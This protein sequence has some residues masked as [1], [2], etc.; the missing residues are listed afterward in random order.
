M[1]IDPRLIERRKAVAE[2]RAARDVGRL[3]RML[4]LAACL[5]FGA[6]LAFSPWLSVAEVRT[7][8]IARSAARAVLAE[9]GVV[10][11]A[12]MIT[13]RPGAVEKALES[14]PWVRSAEV[15]RR[16]PDEVIV[17]VSEREPVAW[18]ETAEGWAR[19]DIDGAA[20][21]GPTA[22]DRTLPRVMLASVAD[23]ES[24]VVLGAIEFAAHL[25][26]ALSSATHIGLEE[27]ELWATV[28]QRRVRLGRPAE[29]KAKALSLAAMLAYDPA[30]DATLNLMAPTRPAVGS[31]AAMAAAEAAAEEAA[32]EAAAQAE[33][34]SETA[35]EEQ[36][37][38]GS[39]T[40]TEEQP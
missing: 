15:G 3:L 10:S 38:A 4:S 30:P 27:G 37:A 24:R 34:E 22:P 5:G 17:R 12:A 36:P 40:A 20:L 23:E 7:A 9:S 19:R 35:T 39:E 28:D 6:W 1:T 25:P 21:P 14:D 33:T 18:V 32:A 11:G 16:W 13:L 2:D 8:G 31:A 29:M 26:D